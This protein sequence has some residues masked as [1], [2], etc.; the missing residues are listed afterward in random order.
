MSMKGSTWRKIYFFL[1]LSDR[2][3][4]SIYV[5]KYKAV[6][7]INNKDFILEGVFWTKR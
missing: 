3:E 2:F 7:F 6:D 4:F 1:T 5:S